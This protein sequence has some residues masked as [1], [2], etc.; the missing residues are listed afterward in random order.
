VGRI[1]KSAIRHLSSSLSRTAGYGFLSLK[2]VK[3]AALATFTNVIARLDRATQ[4]SRA[5]HAKSLTLWN[6]GYSAFAEYD[7]PPGL[8]G[9][10]WRVGV[11]GRPYPEGVHTCAPLRI[12]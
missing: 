12:C 3:R 8:F 10:R 11:L 4:Y 5:F 2:A 7:D 1:S 6:T 9:E